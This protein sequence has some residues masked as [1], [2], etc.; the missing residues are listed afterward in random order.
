MVQYRGRMLGKTYDVG[1]HL[2][3]PQNMPPSV[4][5]DNTAAVVDGVNQLLVQDRMLRVW[6]KVQL[7]ER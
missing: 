5:V 7:R 3:P 6:G 4:S 2:S 1:Q